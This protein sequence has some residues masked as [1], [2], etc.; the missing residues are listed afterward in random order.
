VQPRARRIGGRLLISMVW[1]SNVG[2]GVTVTP[3][4]PDVLRRLLVMR[5]PTI[6]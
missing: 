4:S 6:L 1:D 3:T 2:D 5:S